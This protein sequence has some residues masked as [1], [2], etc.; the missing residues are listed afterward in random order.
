MITTMEEQLD[1]FYL[2]SGSKNHWEGEKNL[3]INFFFS[4]NVFK[5]GDF[6]QILASKIYNKIWHCFNIFCN[7]CVSGNFGMSPVRGR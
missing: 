6:G 5:R 1:S 4:R 3:K 7:F 2:F